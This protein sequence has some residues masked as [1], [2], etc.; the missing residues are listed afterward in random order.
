M[1][2]VIIF[3]L[4]LIAFILQL[5]LSKIDNNLK[6]LFK[7]Y[8]V[9]VVDW[10]FIP[11]NI[12]AYYAI[13]WGNIKLLIIFFVVSIIGSVV[14]HI[15]WSREPLK[16]KYMVKEKGKFYKASFIHLIFS[17]AQLTIFLMLFFSPNGKNV[18]DYG[19]ALMFLAIY[20]IAS[21]FSSYYIHKKYLLEDVSRGVLGAIAVIVFALIKII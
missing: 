6:E 10:V 19:L 21:I 18:F 15:N 16:H 1:I 12:F 8:T 5:I 2:K 13:S 20:F 3:T 9:S 11:F 14:V 17:A 7:N 4:P